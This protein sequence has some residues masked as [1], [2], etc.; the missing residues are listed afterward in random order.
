MIAGRFFDGTSAA[1]APAQFDARRRWNRTTARTPVRDLQLLP[2]LKILRTR[3]QHS[4]AASPFR[5]G[6]VFETRDNDAIDE[7]RETLGF[8][9]GR[10]V[11]APA[12]KPLECSRW[13]PCAAVVLVSVAFVHWGVPAIANR[14]AQV[15]PVQVGSCAS[16]SGTLDMLDRSLFEPSKLP[17][18]TAQAELRK[19]FADMTSPLDDGHQ[20]Q[21]EFRNSADASAPTRSR[22]HPAS[23]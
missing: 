2:T 6:G 18:E 9:G 23:W 11:V 8:N 21:L 20:Y 1:G 14:A 10:R 13:D 12:R 7:A 16:A 4:R 17:A 15:M 3:R 5:N 19:Q 22:C